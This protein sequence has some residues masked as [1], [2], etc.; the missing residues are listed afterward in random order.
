MTP[1]ASLGLMGL[2]TGLTAYTGVFYVTRRPRKGETV[3]VSGAAGAVG[4]VAAQLAKA[5]GARVIVVAGGPKKCQYLAEELKLDGAVDYKNSEKSLEEQIT[6]TCPDGIDFIYDNVGGSI[7][8]QLLAKINPNGRVVICGAVSQYSGNLNKG[9]VEG[10]SNY[11]KLAEKG[12]EMKGFNVMQ[13][14]M[15]VPL[16]MALCGMFY[17]HIRGKVRMT[18]H[19]EVGIQ[20]FPHALAK[21]FSGGSNGHIGKMLVKVRSHMP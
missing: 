19:I 14:M 6:A 5:T 2:T 3:V 20:S 15:K 13:Y 11:L 9:K 17:Y 16:A 10:P 8:D 21:M 1:T 18:E 4:S 12:A 7:L